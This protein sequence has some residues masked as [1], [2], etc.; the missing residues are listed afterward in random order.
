M[1]LNTGAN[2]GQETNSKTLA[3]PAGPN[4][5]KWR[6]DFKEWATAEE[7]HMRKTRRDE[8]LP[9]VLQAWGIKIQELIGL[10]L[11]T[12]DGPDGGEWNR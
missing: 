10:A 11:K 12:Q 5:R 7:E 9:E 4:H 1:F 2:G 8:K 3:N 6:V